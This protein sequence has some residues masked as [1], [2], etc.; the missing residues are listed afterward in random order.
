MQLLMEK[1]SVQTWKWATR[2]V[3]VTLHIWTADVTNFLSD[4]NDSETLKLSVII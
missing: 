1:E 2:D 3:T 4:A